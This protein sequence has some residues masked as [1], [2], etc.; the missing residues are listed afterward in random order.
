MAKAT[1]ELIAKTDNW[2]GG[3]K[4]AQGALHNFEKNAGG[5]NQAIAKGGKTMEDAIRKFG[6]MESK[7][8]TA[9]GRLREMES[10]FM[11]LGDAYRRM[12]VTERQAGVGQAT[13]RSMQQLRVRIIEAR[14]SAQQLQR[15]LNL[16]G[17]GASG[18]LS[19]IGGLKFGIG[20]MAA[21]KA[22]QAVKS[23]VNTNM[24]FEQSNANL[25]AVLG[26]TNKEIEQLTA[27]AKALGGMTKFTASQITELQVVLARRGLGE[28]QI[29]E[30]TH[31]I[32]NLAIATGTDLAQSAELAA[33][34]MQAFGMRATEMERIVSVLGVSTTKSALTTEALG[35]SLQYVAPAARAAGFSLEDTVAILGTLVNNGINASTAGTSLR[36]I[37]L[38]MSTSGGKLAKALGGPV[39][40]FDELV[41]ALQRLKN[42]GG[43]SLEAVSKAV[44]VTALPAFLALVNSA[45]GLN[46]LRDSITGVEGELQ[47]MADTQM[48]TAKGAS[49]VLKSA[50]EGLILTFE[51]SNSTL[52]RTFEW[53]TEIVNKYKDYRNLQNGGQGAISTLIGDEEKARKQAREEAQAYIDEWGRNQTFLLGKDYNEASIPS[54]MPQYDLTK[55]YGESD[56]IARSQNGNP[57]DDAAAELAKATEKYN[58]ILELTRKY[59]ENVV[60]GKDVVTGKD[61]RAHWSY[62]D[63]DDRARPRF[64]G[65]ND[66]YY[67]R[68]DEIRDEIEK[69]TGTRM[70]YA[71]LLKYGE[72]LQRQIYKW[73]AVV[74]M[75]PGATSTPTGVAGDET[76][77]SDIKTSI[78][79]LGKKTPEEQAEERVK[80]AMVDYAASVEKATIEKDAGRLT[81]EQ[82]TNRLL[83]ASERMADAYLDAAVL[84][85][86][87]EYKEAY[88]NNLEEV[89]QLSE[90]SAAL[91]KARKDAEEAEKEAAREAKEAERQAKE[92]YSEKLRL[93]RSLYGGINSAVGKTAWQRINDSGE[94][95]QALSNRFAELNTQLIKKIEIPDD[96]WTK[97]VED[98][99]AKLEELHL[100]TIKV[101]LETNSVTKA[102]DE[103]KNMS[104]AWQ[105]ASQA[106]SSV[107]NAMQSIENPAAKVAGIIAGALAEM[108]AGLGAAI[109]QKGKEIEPW[110]WIAFAA[111]STATFVSTAA[112]VKKAA[113]YHAGGGIAGM[114]SVFKPRGVDTVPAMLSPGEEILPMSSPRHIN[115]ISKQ[116]Q[117]SARGYGDI[118][119]E[120]IITGEDIRIVLTN[121]ARR[122]GGTGKN[123]AI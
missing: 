100:P 104:S 10:M 80:N 106:I 24:E 40:S 113:E 2:T 69:E 82:Y 57:Y 103:V 1:L 121:N 83:S 44:R 95:G 107:G 48:N 14:Q 46:D 86:S 8:A 81:E 75:R 111:A 6:S 19:L 78:E 77:G 96:T 7:A 41:A 114:G 18:G 17:A 99:N 16:S 105:Y 84:T 36:Q 50:W 23:G 92:E 89:K 117:G 39:K 22:V 73:E 61:V 25:A 55:Q 13:I 108:A 58:K 32:S 85:G 35:T 71:N 37:M 91:T 28:S 64:D 59:T 34:T 118:H 49:I 112:A 38:S 74:G 70:N 87:E 76:S 52:K 12:S 47:T 30:M 26:K 5:L 110:S 15:Q 60:I 67:A 53:L 97:F 88:L 120:K 9:S 45:D 115:N 66:E 109:A 4:K 54:W 63:L 65:K 68:R 56:N 33:S 90:A 21:M 27:N 98:L 119:M 72:D 101:D 102:V 93:D 43:N 20:S 94:D 3:I 29:L 31:G 79:K 42:E 62:A 116:I 51:E 11:E 123:Y 122:R